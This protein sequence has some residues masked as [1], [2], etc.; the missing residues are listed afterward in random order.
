[1]HNGFNM[2]ESFEFNSRKCRNFKTFLSDFKGRSIKRCG[3]NIK[4]KPF[5]FENI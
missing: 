1:M 2:L 4:R 5:K 3:S